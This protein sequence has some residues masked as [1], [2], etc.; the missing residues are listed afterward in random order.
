MLTRHMRVF[1]SGET[2]MRTFLGCFIREETGQD[3]IEYALLGLFISVVA[4]LVIA[5][6]GPNVNAIYMDI[7]DGTA[8]TAAAN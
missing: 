2:D 8:A 5:A 1:A 3:L 7:Q 4:T 6:I